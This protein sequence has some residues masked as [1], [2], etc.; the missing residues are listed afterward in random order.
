MLLFG[1]SRPSEFEMHFLFLKNQQDAMAWKNAE[2]NNNEVYDY[3][4]I[5]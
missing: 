2:K 1:S 5:S 4:M 3:V